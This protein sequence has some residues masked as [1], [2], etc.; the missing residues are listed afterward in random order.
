MMQ[1]FLSQFKDIYQKSGIRISFE[2]YI[3]R[4]KLIL[5]VGFII[6]Y[7]L[8]TSVH[9]ILMIE[10]LKVIPST[11]ALSVSSTFILGL[12]L[13]W[14][15]VY[16]KDLAVT[17][18][19]HNLLNSVTFMLLLS[20]GGLSIERIIERVAETEPSKYIRTLLNK[21]IINIKVFGLNPQE[22]LNDIGARSPS[23]QFTKFIDGVVTATQTSG[24]LDKL[25]AYESEVLIQR[26]E[27]E[28]LALLN[29]L[30]FISEIYVTV[31]VIAPLLMIILLT[32]FSFASGDSS[33]GASGINSLNLVV[34]GGIPI[35][36]A[37][38]MILVDMQ[39]TVD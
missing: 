20:K 26:K 32:T 35:I 13:L 15:P 30:G 37:V 12:L 10:G 17:D 16:E 19:E 7:F 21:F 14:Y 31:L 18:I 8:I 28:N 27:E 3:R 2:E 25:F 11:I 6:S 36:S 38:L 1:E 23:D 4:A 33:S 34:F 39:V 5:F 29:N 24:E 9:Y 22:S